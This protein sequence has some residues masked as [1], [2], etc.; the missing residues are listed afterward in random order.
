M[1]VD[2]VDEALQARDD[3][4]ILH[5]VAGVLVLVVVSLQEIV[6]TAEAS[7][8][9]LTAVGLGASIGD[10]EIIHGLIKA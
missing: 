5:A 2:G 8:G 6:C 1:L 7:G 3:V 9:D 4:S 10:A